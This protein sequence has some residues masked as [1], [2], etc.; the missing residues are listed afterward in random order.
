MTC[1]IRGS[2]SVELCTEACGTTVLSTRLNV[3][4]IIIKHRLD[5]MGVS[6]GL[7][8]SGGLEC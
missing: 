3:V 1:V 4:H 7:G 6:L 8:A 5:A 2:V